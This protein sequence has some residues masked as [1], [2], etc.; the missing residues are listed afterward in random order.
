MK[1]MGKITGNKNHGTMKNLSSL[2]L[3]I[4][5]A[6]AT[7]RSQTFVEYIGDGWGP[8]LGDCRP[9]ITDIDSDGLLDLFVGNYG[10][11][12]S[13]F[14][15]TASNNSD[16][17]LLKHKLNDIDVGLFA[18]PAFADI[19]KDGLLDMIIGEWKGNL[20]H[21]EQISI[22]ADSFLLVTEDFDSIQVDGNASPHFTDLDQDGLLDLLIGSHSGN[23]FLYEQ[24]SASSEEFAL[25]SDSLGIDPPTFRINPTIADLDQDG[26]LDLLVGG[27][28]GDLSHFEQSEMGSID[29]TVQSLRVFEDNKP[30]MVAQLPAFTTLTATDFSIL[31]WEKWTACTTIL[32]N[33]LPC[34]LIFNPIPE[35]FQ[36]I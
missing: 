11:H 32:S 1:F 12:I 33:H 19:D 14:E 35:F 23:L 2:L 28:F 22:D 13:H 9:E 15:Q 27:N 6:S 31:S 10:G 5:T 26:L 30:I 29:F 18:S 21:Y 17:S 8:G 34:L 36:T 20:H 4:L 16:F 7:L 25:I 3:I 24:E